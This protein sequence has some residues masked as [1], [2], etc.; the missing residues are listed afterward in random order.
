M[1]YETKIKRGIVLTDIHSL[2]MKL[3]RCVFMETLGN[4]HLEVNVLKFTL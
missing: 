3:N 4:A 2:F 1:F